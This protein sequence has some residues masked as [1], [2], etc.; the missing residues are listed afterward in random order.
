M[1]E[2]LSSMLR[3]EHLAEGVYTH[4]MFRKH[5]KVPTTLEKQNKED[6]EAMMKRVQTVRCSYWLVFYY[7]GVQ[8]FQHDHII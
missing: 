6:D 3:Q 1:D 5:Y 2:Y 8:S 4:Y 7:C